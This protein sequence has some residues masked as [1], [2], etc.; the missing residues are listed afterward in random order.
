[1]S[2]G[3]L[4]RLWWQVWEGGREGS[5]EVSWLWWLEVEGTE[6]E[7][8]GCCWLLFGLLGRDQVRGWQDGEKYVG[9]RTV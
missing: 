4:V 6:E 9:Y 7:H 5:E 2:L 1:M 3:K 8:Q